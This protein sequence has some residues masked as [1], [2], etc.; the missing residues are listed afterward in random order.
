MG[1]HMVSTTVRCPRCSN[2]ASLT[3]VAVSQRSGLRVS[4]S[5]SCS[6]CSYAQES[7]GHELTDSA[8]TAFYAAEGEWSLRLR[9]FGPRRL[10]VLRVLRTVQDRSPAELVRLEG[11]DVVKGALVEIECVEDL[12]KEAGADV[13]RVRL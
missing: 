9:S 7:D 12:L 13:E 4:S 2:P 5:L 11:A 8:R 10:E 6:S 1:R 3:N